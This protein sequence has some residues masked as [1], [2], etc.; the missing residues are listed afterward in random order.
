LDE[1]ELLRRYRENYGL[2]IA[3]IEPTIE[4]VHFH[5]ALERG[6]TAELL[7]SRPEDRWETF[8][9]CYDRLYSS[10]PW[11]TATGAEPDLDV[12]TTVLG[13]PSQRIYEVG[14]GA[15]RLAIGLASRGFEVA[16][17]DISREREGV[18]ASDER[19]SWSLTDGVNLGLFA[20][21]G[22][23][24]VVISDQVIEHLHPDDVLTH[25]RGAKTILRPGGRYVFRTP[26]AYTGPHDVSRVFGFE[27]PVGMH[28]REYTNR[29]LNGMLREAGFSSIRA[30]IAVPPQSNRWRLSTVVISKLLMSYLT[31][32][33]VGLGVLTSDTRRRVVSSVLRGPLKPRIFTVVT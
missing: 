18:R 17:T 29:E 22:T 12:W 25:F 7:A 2:P 14:S 1:E 3:S 21:R 19:L 30:I 24:D 26:H 23:F 8:E 28:L 9:S 10:L 16:A 33:E 13:A 15:G 5:L 6:L 4:Q 31:A 11:L 32:V 20:D 27:R